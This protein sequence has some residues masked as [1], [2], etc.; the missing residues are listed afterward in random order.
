M[1]PTDF[2]FSAPRALSLQHSSFSNVL[3]YSY[4]IVLF[5]ADISL[6]VHNSTFSEYSSCAP[7]ISQYQP[8]PLLAITIDS[9]DEIYGEVSE[10]SSSSASFLNGSI[11]R[12]TDSR[13]E[14]FN[15]HVV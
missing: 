4:A 6:T 2:S 11:I 10:A 7:A 1:Y 14:H 5:E 15:K 3:L 9:L 8:I 13:F 12:I